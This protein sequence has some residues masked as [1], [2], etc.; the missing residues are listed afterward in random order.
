MADPVL[1]AAA[2]LG[3]AQAAPSAPDTQ[4]AVIGALEAVCRPSTEANVRPETS[5]TRERYAS[6]ETP[7]NLPTGKPVRAWLVPSAGPGKVYVLDGGLPASAQAGCILAVYGEPLPMLAGTVQARLA[8]DATGFAPNPSF[9]VSSPR[10]TVSRF[11]RRKGD[12]VTSIIV[13]QAPTPPPDA[14][15]ALV[16]VTRVDYGWMKPGL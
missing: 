11:D 10:Q 14:P 16:V 2:L 12:V 6:V 3:L 8:K 4:A 7:P 5:V 13:V 15:T 1:I 9:S